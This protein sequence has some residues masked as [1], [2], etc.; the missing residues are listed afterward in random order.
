MKIRVLALN[1]KE[2]TPA[3]TDVV[4]SITDTKNFLIFQETANITAEDY[5][6]A[7]VSMTIVQ[8][9]S[10]GS[11]KVKAAVVSSDATP[12]DPTEVVIEVDE[13][14]LPTFEVAVVAEPYILVEERNLESMNVQTGTVKLTLNAKYTTGSTVKGE[15][16]IKGR[17]SYSMEQD[18]WENNYYRN[19]D[20]ERIHPGP[21]PVKDME[22][23]ISL[24]EWSNGGRRSVGHAYWPCNAFL[25]FAIM[26]TDAATGEENAARAATQIVYSTRTYDLVAKDMKGVEVE[27]TPG[28]PIVVDVEERLYFDDASFETPDISLDMFN[29]SCSWGAD[30]QISLTPEQ[31]SP[32]KYRVTYVPQDDSCCT[33][34]PATHDANILAFCSDKCRL[35]SECCSSTK[36]MSCTQAC[37]YQNRDTISREADWKC[38]EACDESTNKCESEDDLGNVYDTCSSAKCDGWSTSV[39]PN[40]EDA[41]RSCKEGCSIASASCCLSELKVQVADTQCGGH[42]SV[43]ISNSVTFTR[44][45]APYGMT[46]APITTSSTIPGTVQFELFLSPNLRDKAIQQQTLYILDKFTGDVRKMD[47]ALF[48]TLDGSSNDD[49][50][51]PQRYT[52]R[53]ALDASSE[54]LVLFS[55]DSF[56]LTALRAVDAPIVLGSSANVSFSASTVLPS[57]A[58]A[59]QIDAL[60]STQATFVR[61]VDRSVDLLMP[62]NAVDGNALREALQVRMRPDVPEETTQSSTPTRTKKCSSGNSQPHFA[63]VPG[64][65]VLSSADECPW[66]EVAQ[67][68]SWPPFAAMKMNGGAVMFDAAVPEMAMARSAP[69]SSPITTSTSA[70]DD[71]SAS[72]PPLSTVRKN[73]PETWLWDRY[74]NG[75]YDIVAPDTMTTWSLT[76]FSVDSVT[77]FSIAAQQTLRVT[78]DLYAKIRLPYNGIRGEVVP[79]TVTI[80]NH[81]SHAATVTVSMEFPVGLDADF[82][83]QSVDIPSEDA[84]RFDLQVTATALGQHALRCNVSR[85]SDGDP[86]QLVVVDSLERVL[87]IKAEGVPRHLLHQQIVTTANDAPARIENLEETN[88]RHAEV[89]R[90][91]GYAEIRVTGDIMGPSIENLDRLVR[92]PFGCGEQNMITLV[93]NIQVAKY[94]LAIGALSGTVKTKIA[95]HLTAGYARELTYRHQDGSFSA[96]GEHDDE[97]SL[98]L[99]AF[100]VYVFSDIA[101]SGLA[102]VD[103][104]IMDAA[105]NWILAKQNKDGF[106]PPVGLVIHKDMMGG[107]SGGNTSLTAYVLRAL[108]RYDAVFPTTDDSFRQGTA[109]GR[110]WL[111]AQTPR[112]SYDMIQRFATLLDI[113]PSLNHYDNGCVLC[114]VSPQ[115][116]TEMSGLMLQAVLAAPDAI[117]AD[118]MSRAIQYQRCLVSKMTALG[119]YGSTQDTCVA[120]TAVTSYAIEVGE[121]MKDI[122]ANV[123]VTDMQGEVHAF[124]VTPVNA[125]VVQR[126]TVPFGSVSNVD[127]TGKGKIIVALA[128]FF[129][130]R[131]SANPTLCVVAPQSISDGLDNFRLTVKFRCEFGDVMGIVNI[132]TWSG[133]YPI[134]SSLDIGRR[135][136][137][138]EPMADVKRIEIDKIDREKI[139]YY[140]D[141]IGSTDRTLEFQV[142]RE[143]SVENTKPGSIELCEYYDETKCFVTDLKFP[144][145]LSIGGDEN[146][147]LSP[148]GIFGIICC[149][150]SGLGIAAIAVYTYQKKKRDEQVTMK[151]AQYTECIGTPYVL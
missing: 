140:Y 94:Y 29:E 77:G 59:L 26:V 61:A 52:F 143:F 55:Y 129:N 31:I 110:A 87:T 127:V 10:L 120:L 95:R 146:D 84:V 37:A 113:A 106:F 12:E 109:M 41:V 86:S 18:P 93:P 100:V 63:F 107:T 121:A 4:I 24:A 108:A 19:F 136:A 133:T 15:I 125:R 11:Y 99:T 138:S 75:T 39:C 65:A 96:F 27:F 112:T 115:Y 128:S 49:T 9:L 38:H 33:L 102:T 132:R 34:D 17:M 103:R 111:A 60:S 46:L 51:K 83:T 36:V 92:M 45:K 22:F 1:R 147:G 69:A 67:C 90:D 130:V 118:K 6:V 50:T 79:V 58:L 54:V 57:A 43:S 150:F 144:T 148:L 68:G 139:S 73:F 42:Y 97:G 117:V 122:H 119:G 32:G 104:S 71:S 5:G 82:P 101:E 25:H 74:M 13:Y 114:S 145:N 2:F 8:G 135:L 89:I 105:A 28:L 151:V 137:S 88:L 47:T 56:T 141:V 85:P 142:K 40:T 131:K 70:L 78:K 91:S 64:V 14:V 53:T 35:Q 98:W 80:F 123:R 23:N 116:E 66:R 7:A 149:G 124:N 48:A 134:A 21:H 81:L 72:T 16:S 20:Y 126:A 76:A 3:I 62:G 44:N 30:R